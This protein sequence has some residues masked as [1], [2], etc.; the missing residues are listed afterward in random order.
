MDLK[1]QFSLTKADSWNYNKHLMRSNP[2][3]GQGLAQNLISIPIYTFL[4]L[5]LANILVL[6]FPL[7]GL[8][9][10]SVFA[11]GISDL[12]FYFN[13]KSQHS[14]QLDNVAGFIGEHTVEIDD[15]GVREITAVRESLH[16]WMELNRVERNKDYL[17]LFWGDT[18]AHIIPVRSFPTG[19][20]ADDFYNAA[21][22]FFNQSH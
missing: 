14:K 1:I 20:E 7:Y 3:P 19:K 22:N 10:M 2:K 13:L 5:L 9:L 18:Q 4:I 12:Y 15:K 21:L 17:Y 11:G 16:T 8:I 6:H